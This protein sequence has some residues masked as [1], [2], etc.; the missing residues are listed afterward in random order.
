[1]GAKLTETLK[2][3]KI[4]KWQ[5]IIL[6]AG[7]LGILLLC[8]SS[9]PGA[10]SGKK[11]AANAA[12]GESIRVDLTQ[13]EQQLERRLCDTIASIAGAGNTRVMLTLDCGSEPIYATQGKTD[14]KNSYS[15]GVGEESLSSSK[16]YV[17]VGSGQGLVLKMIEPQVR[18]VAV[19][20]QGGDDILVRQ[21]I[22]E[23]VTAVLG[24]GSNKVS[25]ARLGLAQ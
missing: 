5:A 12:A 14:Q 17:I 15:E 16:E 13:Y 11:N 2:K 8:I 25:V 1:M 10:G 21:Q 4:G 3:L 20:C 7:L 23:A 19:V 9:L 6:A 18:G 24:V 22:V